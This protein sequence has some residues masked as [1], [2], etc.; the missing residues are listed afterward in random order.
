LEP[1]AAP[2]P[3][4][5][6]RR[7]NAVESLIIVLNTAAEP[8]SVPAELIALTRPIEGHGFLSSRGDSG[9]VLPRYGMFFGTA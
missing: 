5:A 7:R 4:I 8:A 1:V 3:L 9:L 6:F 2:P